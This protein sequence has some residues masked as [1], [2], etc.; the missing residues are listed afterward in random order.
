VLHTSSKSIWQLDCYDCQA[1]RLSYQTDDKFSLAICH[2]IF[3]EQF[4]FCEQASFAWSFSCKVEGWQLLL[5]KSSKFVQ[6][7]ISTLRWNI[8]STFI[9]RAKDLIYVNY[10]ASTRD[11]RQDIKFT[12]H[13]TGKWNSHEQRM[14]KPEISW[15]MPRLSGES[16]TLTGVS[17]GHYHCLKLMP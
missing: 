11:K 15:W 10:M 14:L 12:N 8:R 3:L 1:M 5:P 16:K 4:S 7:L 17:K 2:D 6:L 9:H 13:P